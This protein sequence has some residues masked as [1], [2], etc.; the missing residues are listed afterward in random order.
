MTDKVLAFINQHQLLNI[1]D[2]ILATVSSGIDSVVLCELLHELKI[3]FG[4]AHCNFGLR[5]DESDADEVFVK[6]LA[7]K[8]DVPFFTEHFTTTAFAQQEQISTQMAA[9]MLRYAWFE[10]IRQKNG[11]DYIATAHHQNDTTEMILLNLTR[12]TGIA[13][14][15]GIP[16]KNR[17]IICHLLAL[18]KDVIY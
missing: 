1:T 15:H 13:G 6:K 17:H 7:K 4:I 2:K 12:V 18:T 14:L 9:R 16:V 11:D 10:K 5:G 3:P 8:Y